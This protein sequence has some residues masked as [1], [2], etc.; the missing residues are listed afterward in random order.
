MEKPQL[1]AGAFVY[2]YLKY[3]RVG[4][5]NPQFLESL[6]GLFSTTCNLFFGKKLDK[7]LTIRFD[8]VFGGGGVAHLSLLV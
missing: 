5:V 6:F 2:L 7:K 4:L 3:T 1:L 8:Q